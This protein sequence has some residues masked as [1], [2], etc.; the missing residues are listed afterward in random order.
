MFYFI[1]SF[2]VAL[3]FFLAF[4]VFGINDIIEDYF[5]SFIERLRKRGGKK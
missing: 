3:A 5:L 2:F 4:E 1:V